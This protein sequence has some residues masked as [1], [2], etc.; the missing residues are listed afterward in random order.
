[1]FSG[2]PKTAPSRVQCVFFAFVLLP[3]A[4]TTPSKRETKKKLPLGRAECLANLLI[5]VP[6]FVRIFYHRVCV[7]KFRFVA[8]KASLYVTNHHYSTYHR[9]CVQ[10]V[11]IIALMDNNVMGI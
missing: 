7:Q 8:P 3:A 6:D 11:R 5:R 10:K 1:M 4:Y 9:V 2:T